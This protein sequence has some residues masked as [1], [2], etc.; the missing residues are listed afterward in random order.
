VS[1]NFLKQFLPVRWLC[2]LFEKALV[3]TLA[4]VALAMCLQISFVKIQKVL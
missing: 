1:A 3:G 4:R 2:E